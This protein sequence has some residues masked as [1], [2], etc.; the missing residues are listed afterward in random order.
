[1]TGC[2]LAQVRVWTE[3]KPMPGSDQDGHDSVSRIEAVFMAF[4]CYIVP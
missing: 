3:K 2:F 4:V 1:M